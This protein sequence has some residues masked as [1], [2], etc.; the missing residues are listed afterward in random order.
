[1]LKILKNKANYMIIAGITVLALLLRIIG[2][3]KP[4]GLWYDELITYNFSLHGFPYTNIRTYLW[5]FLYN[6]PFFL[7]QKVFGSSDIMLRGFS[8]IFGILTI[9]AIYMAGKELDKIIKNPSQNGINKVAIVA[10]SIAA[11][12]SLF[13]YYSQEVRHYSLF[14]FISTLSALFMIKLLTKPIK[15]NYIC[16]LGVCFLLVEVNLWGTLFIF[17]QF[18]SVIAY[19]Y[20]NNREEFNKLKKYL[21]VVVIM[22]FLAAVYMIY[23]VLIPSSFIISPFDHFIFDSQVIFIF[24]QNWFSPVLTSLWVNAPNYF[25]ALFLVKFTLQKLIFICLPVIFSLICI[26]KANITV[27]KEFNIVNALFLSAIFYLAIQIVISLS[28]IYVVVTRYT[29]IILPF[30]ILILSY[31]LCR[32]NKRIFI[33]ILSYI[34]SINLFFIL[35][36]PHS[37]PKLDRLDGVKPLSTALNSLPL[38]KND[39]VIFPMDYFDTRYLT[40]KFIKLNI[41]GLFINNINVRLFVGKE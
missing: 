8:V 21:P 9:P 25:T 17:F 16:Y 4:S 35:A 7:W 33:F 37:A 31:G 5:Q 24:L 30:L 38:D 27:K 26:I 28:G 2:L 29:I 41:Q 18:L 34:I 14:F 19:F 13:I 3:D 39:I 20:F 22:P 32:F 40:K 23:A 1:M 15:R 12:N 36:S 10:T 11:L 6:Y